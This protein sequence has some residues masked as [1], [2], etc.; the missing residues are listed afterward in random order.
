MKAF[1]I[2]FL[3]FGVGVLAKPAAPVK[4][5]LISFLSINFYD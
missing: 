4:V 1:V 5:V 2:I 3:A